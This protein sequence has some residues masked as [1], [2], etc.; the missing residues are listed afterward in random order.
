MQGKLTNDNCFQHVPKKN[1]NSTYIQGLTAQNKKSAFFNISL[2]YDP[3]TPADPKIWGGNF[4][5]VSLHGSIKYLASDIKNIK[6]SLKFM[7]KYITNKKIDSSKT[8]DLED[9]KGAEEAVWNFISSVYKANWDVLFMDNKSTLLK[10]KIASKF[11]PR[12]QSTP[13]RANKKNKGPSLAS[14][15]RLPPLILAKSPKEV[16]EISKFFK[17]NKIDNLAS[18][19]TKSYT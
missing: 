4:Y 5:P 16:N 14:I 9:F 13:Q 1:P 10:R 2:S 11:T 12:M 3:D 6:D 18:N 17:S 19:K 15:E 8:N 7:T